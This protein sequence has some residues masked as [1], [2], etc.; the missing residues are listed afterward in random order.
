MACRLEFIDFICQQIASVGEVRYRKMFGDYMIYANDKP[1]VIVCDDIAYVKK[2]QAIEHLMNE[3]E[4]GCPYE[5]AKEHYV[6]DVSKQQHAVDV[7][8]ALETVLPYPKRKTKK[9]K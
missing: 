5:G 2:H 7:V 4:C 6:L 8:K 3:A 1:V 9:N